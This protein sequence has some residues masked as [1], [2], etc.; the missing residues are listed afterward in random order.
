MRVFTTFAIRSLVVAFIFL[1]MPANALAGSKEADAQ[2]IEDLLARFG[3]SPPTDAE[4]KRLSTE[5]QQL[6]IEYFSLDSVD[7]EESQTRPPSITD[8]TNPDSPMLNSAG[9]WTRSRSISA[10]NSVGVTLWTYRAYLNWCG[11]GTLITSFST[12]TQKSTPGWWWDFKSERIVYSVG[13]VGWTGVRRDWEGKFQYCPADLGCVQTHY[14]VIAQ[15]G[16]GN[17][18]YWSSTSW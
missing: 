14:P 16:S 3:S 1:L 12:Y 10:Y 9:C 18:D 8:T 13:D 5:D 15:Q 2:R 4:F 6:L 17:G 7:V 11:D